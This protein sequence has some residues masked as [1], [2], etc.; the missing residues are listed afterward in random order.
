[1]AIHTR[2]LCPPDRRLTSRSRYFSTFVTPIAQSI[3]FSSSSLRLC[4][5]F[6][7]GVR[8]KE[9]SR[10]TVISSAEVLYWCTMDTFRANSFRARFWMFFPCRKIFPFLGYKFFVIRLNSVDL[11]HPFAPMIVVI[12][13]SSILKEVS[14]NT[15]FFP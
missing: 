7:W 1:M 3:S 6:M 13:P 15:L 12:F 4:I 8:P 14:F 5:I 9:T 11:P 2:C 10:S